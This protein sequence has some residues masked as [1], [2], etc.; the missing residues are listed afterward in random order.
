MAAAMTVKSA[1]APPA[2]DEPPPPP[3]QLISPDGSVRLWIDIVDDTK[4]VAA[5][6]PA[7]ETAP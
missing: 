1:D 7:V 6:P 4:P 5:D 3:P 2:A